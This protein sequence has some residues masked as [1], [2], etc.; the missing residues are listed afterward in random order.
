VLAAILLTSLVIGIPA[1]AARH[2][3]GAT[4][5]D[6]LALDAEPFVI[7][8][9]GFGE[10]LG[11]DASRP[12]ENTV[13]AVRRGFKAGVS[14]VEVDVQLTKDHEVVAY[15]DDFLSD[16]TCL[17]TLTRA[18]LHHRL[19]F[20][21]CDDLLDVARSHPLCERCVRINRLRLRAFEQRRLPAHGSS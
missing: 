8:H 7:G 6:L 3:G 20:I 5:E 11:E 9:R 18:E 14:V 17:N 21:C 1:E 10:N 15:H 16:F 13:K 4:V 19:P 12:I 2:H